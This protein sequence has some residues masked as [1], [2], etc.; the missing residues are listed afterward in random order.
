MLLLFVTVTV[1][2]HNSQVNM[3]FRQDQ[4]PEYRNRKKVKI[5]VLNYY[6]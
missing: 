1:I 4:L 2:S 6:Y 3:Y 5:D